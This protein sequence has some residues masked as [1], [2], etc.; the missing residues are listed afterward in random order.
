MITCR[1]KVP[2]PH[3]NRGVFNT[4]LLG[5]LL[6]LAACGGGGG[7]GDGVP[8]DGGTVGITYTGNTNPASITTTNASTLLDNVI[9]GSDVTGS[10]P[11]VQPQAVR[12]PARW[13]GVVS[14]LDRLLLRTRGAAVAGSLDDQTGTGTV[15]VTFDACTTDGETSNGTG[16]LRV[17][18][19]DLFY[20]EITDGLFSFPL[21]TITCA[22]FDVSMSFDMRLEV[23]IDQNLERFTGNLVA[24]DNRTGDMLKYENFIEESVYFPFV[25]SPTSYTQIMRGRLYDSTHGYVDVVTPEVSPLGYSSIEQIYPDTG[26]LVLTGTGSNLRLVTESAT[27]VVIALDSD[28]DQLHESGVTLLWDEIG[29]PISADIGDNDGDSMHNSWETTYGLNP[30]DPADAL[31]DADGDGISN[32]QEYLDRTHPTAVLDQSFIPS[33]AAAYQG[34]II[35]RPLDPDYV[36]QAQTFTVG[37]TG[38]LTNIEVLIEGFNQTAD[39]LVDVRPTINSIPASAD[40]A[41]LGEVAIPGSEIPGFPHTFINAD[42]SSQNI[43]VTSGSELAIVLKI[44]RSSQG[45][46]YGWRGDTGDLYSSGVAYTR[47]STLDWFAPMSD[48][49]T[50]DYGFKTFVRAVR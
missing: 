11:G 28:G 36:D 5:L 26:V 15:T 35:Y 20:Y 41:I 18:A 38:Q 7:G 39:L 33:P 30:D 40:S 48:D 47:A 16:T 14:A 34:N 23:I 19:M 32:Y 17:D 2:Q 43:Q 3:G 37:I 42:F 29:E 44:D 22:E 27:H 6:G 45:G 21:L 12:E 49:L 1:T 50:V 8:T 25:L 24:R 9:D 46:D 10:V 4:L 31:L 13:D